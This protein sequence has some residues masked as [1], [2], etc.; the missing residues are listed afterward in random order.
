MKT[1]RLTIAQALL[2]FLDNQ[3]V[4]QDNT[5]HK[6]VHGYFLHSW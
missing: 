3:Y 4:E 1:I 6:F 5:E 2:R